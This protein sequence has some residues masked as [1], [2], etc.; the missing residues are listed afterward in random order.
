MAKLSGL[1]GD[2]KGREHPIGEFC[3]L[4]RGLEAQIQ[5]MDRAVSR[6]HAKITRAAEHYI[7]EDMESGRGTRVN[8]MRI[9]AS[10]LHPGDEININGHRFRFEDT[11]QERMHTGEFPLVLDQTSQPTLTRAEPSHHDINA[12]DTLVEPLAPEAGADQRR[13]RAL[14]AICRRISRT[15][16]EKT[17]LQEM[18]NLCLDAFPGADR[19]MVARVDR[20]RRRLSARMVR[21]RAEGENRRFH[22]SRWAM[23]EVL[24]K[25]RPVLTTE[26]RK[27]DHGL[28]L[29][30]EGLQ[31]QKMV[32]PIQTLGARMGLLYLDRADPTTEP[33]TDADLETCVAL[34]RAVALALR[35]YEL[36][37]EARARSVTDRQ[38]EAARQVQKR[39]LPRGSPS[40]P[41]FSFVT[42][43][44]P[45]QDVGGDLYDF[46][47]LDANRLALVVGD[48]S[49]KGFP[50]ALVMA[51]VTSQV[52]TAAHQEAN[53][54]DMVASINRGLLEARQDDLFVTLFYGILDRRAMKLTFCNAG[55]LPP[56]VRRGGVG[57]VEEIKV[58]SG[59]P[60]GMFLDTEY[61]QGQIALS[62]GDAVLL[63]SDGVTEARGKG[64][65]M[66]GVGRLRHALARSTGS[67]GDLVSN[68][69][70]DL[71]TF[72]DGTDQADDITIMAL[73]VGGDTED[74]RATLPPGFIQHN[75]TSEGTPH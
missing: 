66:F 35:S 75:F 69:L 54:A 47:Q 55:H 20:S 60:V 64:G 6:Q 5:L 1:T 19:V 56:L 52:R 7:I 65:E 34:C 27:S 57:L 14:T 61:E 23:T 33:F 48:V 49:G 9:T 74:I 32:V 22:I 68:L 38:L 4:G 36:A 17:L 40:I 11:R 10:K 21:L 44:D 30:G 53:P 50:A 72:S 26:V 12:V 59:M 73:G 24:S 63:V 62:Q 16:S 39:F 67:P 29:D 15:A 31:V 18:V 42:H 45:C 2:H 70:G 3:I 51:W 28:T 37:E 41:G 13:L 46:I 25:G 71:R 43:Y 58:P 8:G